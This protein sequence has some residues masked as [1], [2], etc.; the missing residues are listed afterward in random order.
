MNESPEK[1]RKQREMREKLRA[2]RQLSESIPLQ[3]EM[4]LHAQM[5]TVSSVARS[6]A[7]AGKCQAEG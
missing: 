1:E 2:R 3:C 4:Q 7:G 5:E 6:S